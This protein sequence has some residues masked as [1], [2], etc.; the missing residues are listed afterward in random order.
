MHDHTTEQELKE[1]LSR[2][3]HMITKGRRNTERWGWTFVLWGVV[4][5]VAIAW[6]AWGHSAWVWPIT[7][8]IAII[9]TVAI[10]SSKAANIP[11]PLWAG[12][13]VLSG[14]P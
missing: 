10:A 13:S 11:R 7:M 3:E 4:Y 12:R 2:I 14:S 9:V 6:S 8:F 1:R 5:Y